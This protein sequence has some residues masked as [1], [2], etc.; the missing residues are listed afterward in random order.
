MSLQPTDVLPPSHGGP[1]HVPAPVAPEKRSPLALWDRIK[2]LLII[3][4]VFA[5][6]AAYQQSTVPIMSY[7]EALADQLRSKW[8][9]VGLAGLEVLRQVHYLTCERSARY[10]AFWEDHVWGA[11]NR[12][13]SR[14][15][16]WTRFRLGRNVKWLIALGILFFFLSYKW[17][18]SYWAAVAEAPRGCGTTCSGP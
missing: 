13:M 4:V 15:N 1:V 11:W 6:L 18:V 3:A 2:V 16:P 8:W 7:W 10:N 12:R 5:L 17:G 14:L 9:L